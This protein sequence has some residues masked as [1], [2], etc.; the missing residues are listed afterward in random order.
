MA[1]IAFVGDSFCASYN[2]EF[3]KSRGC[4]TWQKGVE[5]PTYLDIVARANCYTL[6]PFGFGGKSWWYSRCRFIE[7]LERL[8][9]SFFADQLETIVFCHTN[10]SRINNAWNRELSNTDSDTSFVVDYYKHIFDGQ[11]NEWAHQQ[12]FKE[13]AEK[14]GHLKTIHFHCFPETVHLSRL[15]PGMVYTTPLIWASVGE[16]TGTDNEITQH[17]I[18]DN[19]FGHRFNHLNAHNNNALAEFILGSIYNYSPGQ[20][21]IDLSNF[22]QVNPNSKRWPDPGFGTE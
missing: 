8:P 13:I 19:Q 22:A 2:Y 14:W 17:L 20:Y 11:F 1:A 6:H 16:L 10:P 7:E 3:W 9:K 5:T 4:T 12:W 18:H 21:E 15:L